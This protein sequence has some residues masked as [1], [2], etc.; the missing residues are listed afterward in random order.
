MIDGGGRY[1]KVL[2]SVG[3]DCEWKKEVKWRRAGCGGFTHTH[4]FF[5]SLANADTVAAAPPPSCVINCGRLKVCTAW[6]TSGTP[7]GS[8]RI[9]KTSRWPPQGQRWKHLTS[10]RHHCLEGSSCYKA[11][12][13]QVATL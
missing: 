2:M 7:V 13:L 5:L 4:T 9:L 11:Q 12:P 3:K 1:W 10:Y 8:I 6:Q